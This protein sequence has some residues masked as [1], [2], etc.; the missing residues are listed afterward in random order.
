MVGGAGALLI[1]GSCSR[2]NPFF[3]AA[4][5][6]GTGGT[7]GVETSSPTTIPSGSQS[8]G[9]SDSEDS[10]GCQCLATETCL[11][12]VCVSMCGEGLTRCDEACVDLQSDGSH[13]GD[14]NRLCIEPTVCAG[15]DCR[16]E[17][18]VGTQ[19]CDGGCPEIDHVLH[20]GGCNM[21][22][23]SGAICVDSQCVCPEETERCG[24]ACVHTADDP[25][26]CGKC[27]LACDSGTCN[28]GVCFCETGVACEG[29][30]FDLMTDE[31][32]CSECGMPCE[33]NVEQCVGG[34]CGC[35]P[36]FTP[37]GDACVHTGSD[38]EHCGGCE[39]CA[40]GD[41]CLGG[42]CT[43]LCSDAMVCGDQCVDLM[44][45]PLHCG[46]CDNPCT[47]DELCLGGSCR[48]YDVPA[49]CVAC[50]CA[51]CE[52]TPCCEVFGLVICAE[53]MVGVEGCN[54]G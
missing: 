21:P 15:G 54:T 49:G 30:C 28:D 23:A 4:G 29:S 10:D 19:E 26:N 52:D 31:L 38:P 27:G 11:D 53:V 25:Y 45:N 12:G 34:V 20:C 9:N 51:A 16:D 44:S 17:C 36:Q 48:P 33:A 40:D 37:C 14:C 41:V 32:N 3:D 7:D 39:P 18:P 42:T 1:A 24:D 6:G 46:E 47:G 22:C 2:D 35:A 43:E 5:S 50:P 13:C 8:D